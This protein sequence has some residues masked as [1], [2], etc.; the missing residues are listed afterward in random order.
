MTNIPNLQELAQECLIASKI[1]SKYYY[2]RK[3]NPQEFQIN[4]QIYLLCEPKK[5]KFGDILGIF[6]PME[7]LSYLLKENLELFI[8]IKYEKLKINQ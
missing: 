4:D 2:D 6:Y 5:G 7:I 8:Q 3:I 1:K